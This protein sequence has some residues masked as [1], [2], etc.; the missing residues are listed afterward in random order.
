MKLDKKTKEKIAAARAEAIVE[1]SRIALEAKAEAEGA[2]A[3]YQA[4]AD[5]LVAKA[6]ATANARIAEAE[7]HAN[8]AIAAAD[9]AAKQ[10]IAMAEAT[11]ADCSAQEQEHKQ[12]MVRAEKVGARLWKA[13]TLIDEPVDDD[14]KPRKRTPAELAKAV[15][16]ARTLRDTHVAKPASGPLTLLTD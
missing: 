10:A 3:A 13:L 9:A 15:A 8:A 1:A 5:E 7:D 16:D 2:V 6:I 14:G 4:E 11:V 12:R